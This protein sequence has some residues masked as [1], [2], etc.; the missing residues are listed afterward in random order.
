MIKSFEM[1]KMV[2]MEK[3]DKV[4]ERKEVIKGEY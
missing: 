2:L 1:W 3:E 4:I